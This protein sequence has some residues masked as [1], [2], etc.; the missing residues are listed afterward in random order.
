MKKIELFNTYGILYVDNTEF[1]F[2]LEDFPL[3][4]SRSWYKDKDGYLISCYN[5]AGRRCFVRF[6]RLVMKADSSQCVD[7]INRNRADNRKQNLRC[8]GYA[9]NNRNRGLY[10][11]NNSGVSGI[12]FD[13]KRHKWVANIS[14]NGKR[15]FLG[16]F[17]D[18]KEAVKARLEKE[19]ELYNEPIG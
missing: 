5:Y 9:E 11:T 10:S 18:K 6:H 14:F 2:D 1:F 12:Y 7:H 15:I 3:I 19:R 17:K 13:K 16:R 4:K 8:C